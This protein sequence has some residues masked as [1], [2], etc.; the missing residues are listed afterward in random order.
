M[1]RDIYRR[2]FEY[3]FTLC[4]QNFFEWICCVRPVWLAMIIRFEMIRWPT[5]IYHKFFPRQNQNRQPVA[6]FRVASVRSSAFLHGK[7]HT[8]TFLFFFSFF[9]WTTPILERSSRIG[10]SLVFVVFCLC[11]LTHVNAYCVSHILMLIFPLSSCMLHKLARKIEIVTRLKAES[12]TDNVPLC[13]Y[14]YLWRRKI[15]TG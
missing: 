15:F 8:L 10:C 3:V 1:W 2:T 11:L 5:E 12:S 9:K 6:G 7:L 14:P 13:Q 4:Y